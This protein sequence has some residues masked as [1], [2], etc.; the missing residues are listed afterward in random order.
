[1]A[2]ESRSKRCTTTMSIDPNDLRQRVREQIETR[3]NLPA[4]EHAK[5]IEAVEVESM[6]RFHRT[7][8]DRMQGGAA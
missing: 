3:L 6:K 2:R 4:W 5:H 7:W 8:N 1:M